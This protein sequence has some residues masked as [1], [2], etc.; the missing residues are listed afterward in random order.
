MYQ[1][2]EYNIGYF[3][4]KCTS[5]KGLNLRGTPNYYQECISSWV[6]VRS[7]LSKKD[8]ENI[9][10]SC[11]FGNKYLTHRNSPV[12]ISSFC[13]SNIR[14]VSDIWDIETNTCQPPESIRDR[15]VYNTGCI[16]KYDKIKM[17]FSPDILEILKGAIIPNQHQKVIVSNEVDISIDNILLKPQKL[18]LFF[19][20]YLNLYKIFNRPSLVSGS[21]DNFIDDVKFRTISISPRAQEPQNTLKRGI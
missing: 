17:S 3:V 8:K 20:L 19:L 11:L 4:C 5:I 18:K 9:L 2:S 16:A 6:K 21:F 10:D 7:V 15:L 1:D 12:F 14:T 13:K